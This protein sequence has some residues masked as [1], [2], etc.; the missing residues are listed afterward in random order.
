MCNTLKDLV[1]KVY[2][3]SIFT[4]VKESPKACL[5]FS[6]Q[7][8]L[9]S[10]V[11]MEHQVPGFMLDQKWWSEKMEVG[12]EELLDWGIAMLEYYKDM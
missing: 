12:E 5:H 9:R 8:G 4:E 2:N 1:V 3:D 11:V 10:G 6:I 7:L